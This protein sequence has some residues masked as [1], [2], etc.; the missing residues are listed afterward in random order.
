MNI[1]ALFAGFSSTLVGAVISF[2]GYVFWK[3]RKLIAELNITKICD[4]STKQSRLVMLKGKAKKGKLLTAPFSG[5]KCVF[6]QYEIMEERWMI[7]RRMWEIIAKGVSDKAPFYLEDET[8]EILIDPHSI[9]VDIPVR[10]SFVRKTGESFPP[11]LLELI[12]NIGFNH[13]IL[14]GVKKKLKFKEEYILLDQEILIVG[15]VKRMEDVSSTSLE[16]QWLEKEKAMKEEFLRTKFLQ[17]ENQGWYE[18]Q[19]KIEEEIHKGELKTK[20]TTSG[21]IMIGKGEKR[22]FIVTNQGETKYKSTL[23]WRILFT[24]VGGITFVSLGIF[25]ILTVLG[26]IR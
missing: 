25:I 24:F 16:Y 22:P 12:R 10:Y 4:L 2:F 5:I 15:T 20:E 17:D 6:Y 3:R 23:T 1:N 9:E 18:I 21:K 26:V 8:G 13:E 7:R 11:Q 14:R 19:S